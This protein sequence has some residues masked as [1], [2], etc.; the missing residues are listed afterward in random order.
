MTHVKALQ[1]GH[2]SQGTSEPITGVFP[3]W[4]SGGIPYMDP[5]VWVYGPV[6]VCLAVF[7]PF[8]KLTR[9]SWP[10]FDLNLIFL[11]PVWP[12]SDLFD[13]I[14]TSIW[15]FWSH[16]DLNLIF[17]TPFF[18]GIRLWPPIFRVLAFFTFLVPFLPSQRASLPKFGWVTPPPPPHQGLIQYGFR[19]HSDK[20]YQTSHVC[21]LNPYHMRMDA[22]C[23]F[24]HKIPLNLSSMRKKLIWKI[25]NPRCRMWYGIRSELYLTLKLDRGVRENRPLYLG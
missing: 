5:P 9:S 14:L 16:F 13:P 18:I 10:H 11:T 7:T 6:Y 8:L 21:H 23:I 3:I 17:L 22:I 19:W 25:T 20:P 1:A 15:S 2:S 12:Q 24:S 4:T